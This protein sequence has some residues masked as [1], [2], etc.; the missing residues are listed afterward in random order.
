MQFKNRQ[1]AGK[2]LAQKMLKYREE[3]NLLVLALPRGGVPVAVEVAKLLDA[4][5]DLFMVRKLGVPNH[6]ELALG[7]VATGGARV[8]NRKVIEAFHVTQ[9]ELDAVIEA[10]MKELERRQ[11]VYRS[12][13]PLPQIQGRTIILID[14]GLAT[15]ASMRAAILALSQQKPRKIIVGVPTASV[16]TCNEFRQYVDEIVCAITPDQFY[17]VGLWYK[18]FA[19]VTD[20]EVHRL[21]LDMQDYETSLH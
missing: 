8:L 9:A 15:G 20:E 19:Q 3:P 12:N 6:E 21:M 1:A 17:A 10:E 11:R 16:E 5:M 2:F 14:D 13:R 18:D 7:A 4:P